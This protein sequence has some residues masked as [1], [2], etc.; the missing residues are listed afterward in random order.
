M[1]VPAQ[2]APSVCKEAPNPGRP[3]SG[4]VGA[5]DPVTG[6]KGL[7]DSVYREVGYS[8]LNWYTYDLGCGPEGVTNPNAYLDTWS[9]NQVFNIA[10]VMVGTT[11]SLHA[12]LTDGTLLKPLDDMIT[13]GSNALYNTVFTPWFGIAALILAIIMFR[14]IWRGDLATISRKGLW[15]MAG[16]WVATATYLTPLI[17][18]SLLDEI[19]VKGTAQVQSG[20]LSEAGLSTS[21]NSLPTLLHENVVYRNWLRGEFGSPDAPQAKDLG[22]DLVRAQSWTVEEVR[23]NQ[24]AGSPDEKK[25]KFEEIASKTGSTYGYFKGTEGSRL[26]T[27]FLA[28]L[29]A[30]A[31]TLFQ[32]LAKASI[33]LGQVLLRVLI[34]TGPIIGLIAILYHDILRTVGRMVGSALLNVL[35]LAAMAGLH[36]MML[37]AIFSPNSSL[38]LVTQVLLAG[39]VTLV[40]LLVGK[41]VRRMW[42][43]V[44]LSVGAMSS[45][46]PGAPSGGFW[47]RFGGRPNGPTAQDDFWDSVRGTDPDDVG[48]AKRSTRRRSRPEALNPVISG[49]RSVHPELVAERSTATA[50]PPARPVTQAALPA[51]P[52]VRERTGEDAIVVPS[53]LN[54]RPESRPQAI[55]RRSEMETVAGRPAWVVYR[56]SRGLE[57]RDTER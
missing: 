26:G 55:A 5:L 24:D 13:T 51:A 45:T 25:K 14:S 41:P 36:T 38:T 39:L 2:A 28:L 6:S 49:A 8:G 42:Q 40:F 48:V 35:V 9:G 18:T 10:K 16:L 57:V 1:G 3:N 50:L 33:L 32:L 7:K 21:E 15:A 52:I 34:L 17:Y 44:E 27:G 12:E 4:M 29:Q 23:N 43:M 56:P 37:T 46:L 20:F 54:H 31:F 22:R 47:S 19:L 53:R 30:L 11:N